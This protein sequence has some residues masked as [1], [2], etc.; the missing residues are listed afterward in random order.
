MKDLRLRIGAGRRGGQTR[1]SRFGQD[2]L[3]AQ[4][5]TVS[6]WRAGTRAQ[7]YKVPSPRSGLLCRVGSGHSS[8][9]HKR[10]A[11]G[12][13]VSHGFLSRARTQPKPKLGGPRARFVVHL[14]GFPGGSRTLQPASDEGCIKTRP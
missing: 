3:P 9:P 4:T 10:Q 2:R 12:G 14:V 13:D 8:Q 7:A 5:H 6:R 11:P 1:K